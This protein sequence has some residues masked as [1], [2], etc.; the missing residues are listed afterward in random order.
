MTDFSLTEDEIEEAYEVV[1]AFQKRM[2]E[3]YKE[4][5]EDKLTVRQYGYIIDYIYDNYKVPSSD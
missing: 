3:V 2:E 5:V 1:W 4:M